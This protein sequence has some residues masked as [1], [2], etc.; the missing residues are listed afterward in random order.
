MPKAAVF[1]PLAFMEMGTFL[2]VGNA[3]NRRG[4]VQSPPAIESDFGAERPA[5]PFKIPDAP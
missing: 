2:C 4:V 3:R 1:T 5:L